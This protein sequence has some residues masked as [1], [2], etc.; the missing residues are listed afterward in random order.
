MENEAEG[1]IVLSGFK[2]DPSEKA[3]VDNLIENYK[4]KISR[5]GFKEIK[6][7]MKKSLRGK[8]YLHQIQGTLT[9]DKTYSAEAEDFNLLAAIADT[10]EKLMHEI[11]HNTRKK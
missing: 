2:L 11:E 4:H 5:I 9:R 3:I 8:N 7:R 10:F 1:K 6:L